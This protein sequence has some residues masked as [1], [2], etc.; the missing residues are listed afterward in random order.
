MV[1]QF[2]SFFLE[3]LKISL[4]TISAIVLFI[5]ANKHET[6]I[7]KRET[8]EKRLQD[9]YI[10]FYQMCL[11]GRLDINRLSQM[12]FET[13]SLFLDL[14]VGNIHLMG[15]DSQQLVKQYYS[16][17]LDFLEADDDN[18]LYPKSVAEERLDTAFNKLRSSISSEYIDICRSLKLP[19]PAN[20]FE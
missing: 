16:A 14:F 10:P 20:I 8:L 4:P 18:P 19:V 12:D 9:F 5:L 13:R 6:T 7:K 2:L 11:R 3:V 17:Y 1:Q 15:C